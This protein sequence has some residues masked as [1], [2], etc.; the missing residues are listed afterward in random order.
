LWSFLAFNFYLRKI[1][2]QEVGWKSFLRENWFEMSDLFSSLLIY[3]YQH[4]VRWAFT[5]MLCSIA[6]TATLD[7]ECSNCMS[8]LLCLASTHLLCVN[9]QN[10][11]F[12]YSFLIKFCIMLI[13]KKLWTNKEN[14]LFYYKNVK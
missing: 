7:R 13:K 2:L 1:V 12:F 10:S 14:Y 3:W 6:G 9:V 5:E 8:Y 4:L 11:I